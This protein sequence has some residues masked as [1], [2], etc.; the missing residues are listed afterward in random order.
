MFIMTVLRVEHKGTE[1]EKFDRIN[2]MFGNFV[3]EF[4]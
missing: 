4:L 2:I 1:A 3:R